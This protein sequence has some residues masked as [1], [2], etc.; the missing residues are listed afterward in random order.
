MCL[1]L[2][3]NCHDYFL[4]L[5]VLIFLLVMFFLPFST[6]LLF[7]S[8][9]FFVFLFIAISIFTFSLLPYSGFTGGSVGRESTCNAGLRV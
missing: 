7:L 6:P 1:F 9:S 3:N 5:F 2:K 8:R 4:F